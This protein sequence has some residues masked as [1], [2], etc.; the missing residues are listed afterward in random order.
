MNETRRQILVLGALTAV[1]ATLPLDAFGQ[2][3]SKPATKVA[4]P[5]QDQYETLSL[6]TPADFQPFIGAAFQA[7]SASSGSIRMVLT[8]VQNPPDLGG[9]KQK[10]PP[11]SPQPFYALRFKFPASKT[12][13]QDTYVFENSGLPTFAMFVVPASGGT[14]P[15]FCTGLVNQ[16]TQ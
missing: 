3:L 2:Y 10:N 14:K 6:L 4:P 13:Q 11:P 5:T 9:T 15:N 7:H 8:A 12:L 16:T 1:S